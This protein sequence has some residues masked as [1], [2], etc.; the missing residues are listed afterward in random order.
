MKCAVETGSGVM[1]YIPR[2]IRFGSG[3][4]KLVGDTQ[5]HRQD[6]DRVSLIL[7]FLNKE[8]VI[9]KFTRSSGKN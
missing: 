8:S 7:F 3:I 5:T 2:L 9:I 1:I 6:V 4:H